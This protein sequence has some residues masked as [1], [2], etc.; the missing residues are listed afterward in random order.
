MPSAYKFIVGIAAII[1]MAL[2]WI[3]LNEVFGQ[4]DGIVDTFNSVTTDQTIIN[5][6]NTMRQVYYYS[7]LVM[8]LIIGI[9]ILKEDQPAGVY[10]GT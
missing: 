7:L 2:V 1:I 10:Y 4:A 5:Y 9:W 6:N 3:P 8:I